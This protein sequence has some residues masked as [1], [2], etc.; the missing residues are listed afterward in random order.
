[1]DKENSLD[2]IK[3]LIRSVPS[4]ELDLEISFNKRQYS[5]KTII[6]ALASKIVYKKGGLLI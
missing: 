3:I 1:M 5:A 6:N 2:L 4:D